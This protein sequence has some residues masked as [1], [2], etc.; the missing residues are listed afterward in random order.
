MKDLDNKSNL[1]R[2]YYQTGNMVAA[3]DIHKKLSTKANGAEGEGPPGGEFSG[4]ED[5]QNN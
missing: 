4:D 1:M 2:Y 3:K 5:Q